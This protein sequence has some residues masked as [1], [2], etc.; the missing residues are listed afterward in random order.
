MPPVP[1]EHASMTTMFKEFKP[2]HAPST[3]TPGGLPVSPAMQAI[4]VD[5]KPVVNP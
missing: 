2:D 3:N 4:I 1:E 5:R